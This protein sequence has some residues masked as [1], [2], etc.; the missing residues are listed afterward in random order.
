MDPK[1]QPIKPPSNSDN[2][3]SKKSG[4][5]VQIFKVA[6]FMLRRRRS[7]KSKASVDMGSDKGLWRRLLGSMRPLHIQGNA[8]PPT[9]AQVDMPL[10]PSESKEVFEEAL[11]PLPSPS[12]SPSPSS[13]S[14]SHTSRSSSFGTSQYASAPNLQELDDNTEGDDDENAIENDNGGDEMIDAKAE[15][16]IA[17][18]Y[19]QM[20]R[21]RHNY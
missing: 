8:S 12:P 17:Q 1:S 18:F 4:G 14:F 20:R 16:F 15:E 19:E 21:Q 7:K 2:T 5:A 3:K 10:A 6:F 9:T 11:M 13:S